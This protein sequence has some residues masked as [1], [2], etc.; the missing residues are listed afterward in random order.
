[1]KNLSLMA[2]LSLALVSC[3]MDKNK[4]SEQTTTTTRTDAR[5]RDSR[6]YDSDNTA[7]NVRDRDASAK[8]PLD[9]AENETD[10]TITQKIRQAVVAHD[11]LSTNAKNIKIITSNG[12][13]IL[14]GPVATPEEREMIVDIVRSVPGIA[15]V[16]NR[17][18][19]THK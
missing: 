14:R 10:R 5:I 11:R 18:E 12:I 9:Q 4:A 3:E 19:V 16:D 13:V 15:R 1:M 2:V 8:T 7:K 6:N 17:L